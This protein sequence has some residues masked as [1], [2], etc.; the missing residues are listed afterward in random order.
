[1]FDPRGLRELLRR[2][3]ISLS[4]SVVVSDANL[5]PLVASSVYF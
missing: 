3:L 2:N 4:V 1:M 5:A